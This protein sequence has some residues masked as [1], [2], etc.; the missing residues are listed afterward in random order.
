[1]FPR[2]RIYDGTKWSFFLVSLSSIIDVQIHLFPRTRIYD[3]TKWSFFLVS[4]SSIIDVQIRMPID[5]VYKWN[6]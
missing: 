5:V 6:I 1:M 2:T 3:G 4:L